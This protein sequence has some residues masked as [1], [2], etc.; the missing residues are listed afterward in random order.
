[1]YMLG[2]T[3]ASMADG[4]NKRKYTAKVVSDFTKN[5]FFRILSNRKYIGEYSCDRRA[6]KLR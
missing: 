1:M 6:V 5:S 3:K 2:Y 4:L